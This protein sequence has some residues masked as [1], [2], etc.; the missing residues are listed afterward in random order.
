MPIPQ[1]QQCHFAWSF[2]L[3]FS[4]P[5]LNEHEANCYFL[6]LILSYFFICLLSVL[7][8]CI[9]SRFC[10]NNFRS[11]IL[12]FSHFQQ[13]LLLKLSSDITKIKRRQRLPKH[14][15]KRI[16]LKC[17]N[18]YDPLSRAAKGGRLLM[19]KIVAFFVVEKH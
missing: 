3:K 14:V 16:T 19:S 8:S 13:W 10:R 5:A 11:G 12:N 2:N 7:I 1:C 18:S 17:S 15:H 9:D 4:Q 6:Q